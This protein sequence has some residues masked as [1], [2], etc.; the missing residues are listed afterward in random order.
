MDQ[1]AQLTA[2]LAAS[3]SLA[4]M[5]SLGAQSPR[6]TR[7]HP[8][9]PRSVSSHSLGSLASRSNAQGG[10]GSGNN[11]QRPVSFM[12]MRS[13]SSN[14]SMDNHQSLTPPPIRSN[15]LSR[16][17]S[18]VFTTANKND[19]PTANNPSARSSQTKTMQRMTSFFGKAINALGL[20][21]QD[22]YVMVFNNCDFV[23]FILITF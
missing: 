13:T 10:G 16:S 9:I 11:L 7:S 15:N 1:H 6:L 5:A 21:D 18:S 22:R 23:V 4:A 2:T 8:I 14:S 20:E 19:N 12:R 3:N 17:M